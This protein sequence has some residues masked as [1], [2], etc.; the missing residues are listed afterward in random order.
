MVRLAFALWFL[1]TP[2]WI[3]SCFYTVA[4][5]S[6]VPID[7]SSQVEHATNMA[8]IPPAV[9]LVGLVSWLLY[10]AIMPRRDDRD[11]AS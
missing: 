4:Q 5:D 8:F 9:V 10:R 3:L 6:T 1:L 2:I 7:A 11:A